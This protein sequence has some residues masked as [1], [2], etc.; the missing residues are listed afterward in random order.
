MIYHHGPNINNK[1]YI[2][3]YDTILLRIY[4]ESEI[5]LIILSFSY[6]WLYYNALDIATISAKYTL[7]IDYNISF[8][9][10]HLILIINTYVHPT[11]S[12]F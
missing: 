9:Y 11:K 1:Q 7:I 10:S 6:I 5:I 4:K 2:S 3:P 8:I 12:F